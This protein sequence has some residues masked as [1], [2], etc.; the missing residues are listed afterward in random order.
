MKL[1]K[2]YNI[3]KQQRIP[4]ADVSIATRPF[5]LLPKVYYPASKLEAT[6]SWQR[7]FADNTVGLSRF[8][9]VVFTVANDLEGIVATLESIAAQSYGN[10]EVVMVIC[11]QIDDLVNYE[12]LFQRFKFSGCLVVDEKNI[13]AG[14]LAEILPYCEGDY[15]VF[16]DQ[17]VLWDPRA[18][19]VVAKQIAG[20]PSSII[21]S[22]EV[23]TDPSDD[24]V[25][26]VYFRRSPIDYYAPIAHD[27]IGEYFFVKKDFA[28]ETLQDTPGVI[29]PYHLH[30]WF[31]SL[32]GLNN[33]QQILFIP[34]ALYLKDGLKNTVIVHSE[35]VVDILK[36]TVTKYLNGLHVDVEGIVDYLEDNQLYLSPRL[37]TKRAS[38]TVIIPFHNKADITIVAIQSLVKQ[39]VF[40]DLEI[41]LVDN[42]S[43]PS[44]LGKIREFLEKF[45]LFD[46]VRIESD[47]GYFN[48]AKLNNH[49]AKYASTEFVLFLNN[50]VEFLDTKSVEELVA[51]GS[52]EDVGVVGGRLVFEDGSLQHAGINFSSVRPANVIENNQFSFMLRE[53]NAVTFALALVKTKV[54]KEIGGLDEFYCPNAFGD[55]LFCKRIKEKG[56]R[57][58]Y[59]PG[60]FGVHRESISRGK[61]S[62]ELELLEM[63]QQGLRISDLYSEFDA[64]Y[65]PM[66]LNLK[67]LTEAP[68][69]QLS[70]K[71]V[72]LKFL[73]SFANFLSRIILKIIQLA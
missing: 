48:Y 66:R 56:Y 72:R 42:R 37:K 32:K 9:V 50:D 51:W 55:A 67:P 33:K 53:V 18:F 49:V 73:G 69:L 46:K 20:T 17:F 62:E 24:E 13:N 15:L 22:N 68:L 19:F 8:S 36:T 52:I 14:T 28:S 61:I 7:H 57:I 44:E 41:V 34:L 38:I 4:F 71:L 59:T 6:L 70:R 16:A 58:I 64:K 11:G 30:G 63:N 54:L 21:Y 25:A 31:F 5:Q 40:S 29:I 45:A 47:G 27:P 43:T 65:Q 26:D 3:D 2:K 1:H 10:Y 60:A 23:V 35:D 12:G 39:S